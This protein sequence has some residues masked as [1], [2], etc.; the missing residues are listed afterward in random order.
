MRHNKRQTKSETPQFQQQKHT[1]RNKHQHKQT[2]NQ[3]IK[4]TKTKKQKTTVF[5]EQQKNHNN[6][7][8]QLES[9][10]LTFLSLNR[11]ETK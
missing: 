10:F 2:K 11:G 9:H 5:Q 1:T 6:T 7:K 8:M 3:T 4:Q